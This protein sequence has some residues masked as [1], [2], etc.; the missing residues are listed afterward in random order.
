MTFPD[1]AGFAG[2]PHPAWRLDPDQPA[3]PLDGGDHGPGL[4]GPTPVRRKRTVPMPWWVWNT[5]GLTWVADGY[6]R[7]WDWP[8]VAGWLVAGWLHVRR[9]RNGAT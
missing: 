5:I 3:P 8:L 7:W 4:P 1:E 6:R 9:A 2:M